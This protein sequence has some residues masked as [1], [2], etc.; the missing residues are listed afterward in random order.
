M[1]IDTIQSINT[2]S[3][4]MDPKAHNELLQLSGENLEAMPARR[5]TAYG[6][7]VVS[8]PL[9]QACGKDSGCD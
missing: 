8:L 3:P 2:Q 9:T 4:K 1:Y 7:S 6:R 5:R